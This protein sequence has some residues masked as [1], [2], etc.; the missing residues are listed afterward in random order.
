MIIDR[1]II[2]NVSDAPLVM[3][4]REFRHLGKLIRAVSIKQHQLQP[5]ESTVMYTFRSGS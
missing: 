2:T 5:A 4:E 1:Y 3:E